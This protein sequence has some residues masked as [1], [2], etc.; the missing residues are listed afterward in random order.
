MK[1]RVQNIRKA[2]QFTLKAGKAPDEKMIKS[3]ASPLDDDSNNDDPGNHQ[4]PE[5]KYST[6]CFRQK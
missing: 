3:L 1:I 4:I 6:C 2:L 5:L